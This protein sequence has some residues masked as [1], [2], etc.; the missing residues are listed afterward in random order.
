V[1]DP[2]AEARLA[3]LEE[4]WQRD[5]GSRIFLQLAEELRRVGRLSRAIEVL[6]QGLELHPGYPSAQVALG[7]CLLEAGETRQAAEILEAALAHDPT[8]LVA[9]KLAVEAH[10]RNGESTEARAR[11]ELYR[12]FNDR[13]DEIAALDARLRALES[14]ERVTAAAAAPAAVSDSEA[15]EPFVWPAPAPGR[16][17]I[18]FAPEPRP[19]FVRDETPFGRWSVTGAAALV[20][21]ACRRE[22]IF[23]VAAAAA[24]ALVAPPE[25]ESWV[26]EAPAPIEN[27]AEPIP[28]PAM[29][30]PAAA[31]E[32]APTARAGEPIAPPWAGA[33]RVGEL[34]RDEAV[35]A[36]PFSPR[37]IG[38][39]VERETIEEPFDEVYAPPSPPPRLPEPP[40]AAPAATV[41]LG[42]L[43]LEQGHLD[44]AEEAFR[45]V[46]ATRPA[47][48]AAL[49]GLRETELRRGALAAEEAEETASG[50]GR[51]ESGPGERAPG[52]LTERKIRVLRGYL[53]R[54]RRGADSRV[55]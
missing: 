53:S 38:A 16:A 51:G 24:V 50:W 18:E 28:P 42:R 44:S 22:G 20:A 47:D 4:R 29:P 30:A 13:D 35:F 11:L 5:P 9:T 41:T 34:E 15:D 7:R 1:P 19:R 12:L 36:T 14:G 40:A 31:A 55:P 32:L 43:Y 8:Q 49:A 48:A 2:Q 17:P 3:Q 26:P 45:A 33:S 37:E 39:E 52:S 25:I 21:G 6:R 23:P 54:I 10:L 27:P 46:L